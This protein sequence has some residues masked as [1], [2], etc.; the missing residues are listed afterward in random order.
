MIDYESEVSSELLQAEEEFVGTLPST[1]RHQHDQLL[2]GV[3]QNIRRRSA[4]QNLDAN[5]HGFRVSK[6]VDVLE[7]LRSHLNLEHKMTEEQKRLLESASF[8]SHKDPLDGLTEPTVGG[9]WPIAGST[10]VEFAQEY[11]DTKYMQSDELDTL[12]IDA[13]IYREIVAYRHSIRNN[14]MLEL[15]VKRR[16]DNW[17]RAVAFLSKWAAVFAVLVFSYTTSKELFLLI[18]IAVIVFQAL[19]S[20]H[21]AD[22]KEVDL[23]KQMV[24]VYCHCE[25]VNFN[26]SVVWDMCKVVRDNGA[27][28]DGVMYDLLER[29]IGKSNQLGL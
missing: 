15:L 21:V 18:G 4:Q 1:S 12:L 25:P 29:Q 27:V 24:F 23:Y 2:M 5:S 8:W 7:E 26:A 13:L 20:L 3:I 16:T 10:L 11:F 9:E 28:F 17:W 14:K 22:N 19:K 6:A